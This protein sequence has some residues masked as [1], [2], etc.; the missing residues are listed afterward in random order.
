MNSVTTLMTS[1]TGKAAEHPE[2]HAFGLHESTGFNPNTI[3]NADSIL[4]C[5][6]RAKTT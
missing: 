4:K 3:M 2:W 6:A 5:K 1:H